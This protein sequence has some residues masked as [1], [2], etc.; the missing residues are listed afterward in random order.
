MNLDQ[1]TTYL[2]QGLGR[3]NVYLQQHDGTLYQEV[4][5][6]AC[7]YNHC[8]DRDVRISRCTYFYELMQLTNTVT[9][10]RQ[11]ILDAL[12]DPDEEMDVDQLFDFALLYAQAGDPHARQV[13]YAQCAEQTQDNAYIG[14]YQLIDLD[15]IEAFLFIANSLGEQALSK[16]EPFCDDYLLQRLAN[17]GVGVGVKELRGMARGRY[18]F[19]HIY[20][21]LIDEDMQQRRK[22][23]LQTRMSAKTYAQIKEQLTQSSKRLSRIQLKEWSNKASQEDL[24]RA[25]QDLLRQTDP[26]ILSNYLILFGNQTFPLGFEP[27][28]PF[29]RHKDERVVRG[30]IQA[31]SQLEHTDIRTLAFELVEAKYHLENAL[32]LFIHNYWDGDEAYF[33]QLLEETTDIDTIHAIGFSLNDIFKQHPTANAAPIFVDLYERGPCMLCRE[34]FVQRL[35]DTHTLPSYIAREAQ[36]DAEESIRDI[37]RAYCVKYSPQLD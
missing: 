6:Q 36:Y 8:Y 13:M 5:L 25:A 22:R 23:T 30:A 19:A 33:Q 26:Q 29:I 31:V 3:P 20:L 35:I 7:L 9:M 12:A 16:N 11:P 1:C 15:G 28:L 34:D 37:V 14:T 32:D 4:L 21:D 2:F 24:Q 18:P 17:N 10:F 27:L